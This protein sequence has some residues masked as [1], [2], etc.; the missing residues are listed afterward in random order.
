MLAA[1]EPVVKGHPPKAAPAQVTKS[2]AAADGKIGGPIEPPPLH[3]PKPAAA[4][5]AP[6]KTPEVPG[7]PVVPKVVDPVGVTV[8][9][10]NGNNAKPDNG[11]A[12]PGTPNAPAV[13]EQPADPLTPVAPV[14]AKPQAA[15]LMPPSSAPGEFPRARSHKPTV[16]THKGGNKEAQVPPSLTGYALRSELRNAANPADDKTMR[17]ERE[18]LEQLASDIARSRELL[19]LETARLEA[20]IKSVAPDSGGTTVS[21]GTDAMPGLA[22]LLAATKDIPKEQIDAVSKQMKGMKPEQAGQVI[23]RLDRALAAE[24]LRRMRPNDAGAVLGFVKPEL[25]AELATVMATRPPMGG[26]DVTKKG[27]AK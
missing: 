5:V 27:P 16:R 24:I 2:G 14:K 18:K 19:R 8:P 22:A 23:S 7:A 1:G 15:R 9:S 10:G 6:V 17:S 11:A 21:G 4:P 12:K 20:L 3:G 13:T 25:A 26:G